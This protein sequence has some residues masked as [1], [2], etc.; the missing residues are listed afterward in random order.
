MVFSSRYFSKSCD[1]VFEK[2]GIIVMGLKLDG[3]G[4]SHVYV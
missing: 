1:K 3:V 4:V 2:Y